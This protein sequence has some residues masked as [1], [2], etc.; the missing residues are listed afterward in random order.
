MLRWENEAIDV[1]FELY[2]LPATTLLSVKSK[3]KER[4]KTKLNKVKKNKTKNEAKEVPI[5][6][7]NT[8]ICPCGNDDFFTSFF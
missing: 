7:S 4:K 5:S 6:S 2:P 8:D 1:K 3:E